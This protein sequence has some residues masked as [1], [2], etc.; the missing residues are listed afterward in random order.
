MDVNNNTLEVSLFTKLS[1]KH[2]EKIS[3]PIDEIPISKE[4]LKEI[5]VIRFIYNGHIY[6]TIFLE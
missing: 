3:I 5:E 2:N 4:K 6:K 1:L